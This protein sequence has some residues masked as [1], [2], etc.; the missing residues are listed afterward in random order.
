MCP[1]LLSSPHPGPASPARVR[2][3]AGISFRLMLRSRAHTLLSSP[4]KRGPIRRDLSKGCGVWVPA[5]G[6]SRLGRDDRPS[7]CLLTLILA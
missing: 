6:A 4:R 2:A 1:T 3:P 5:R 7:T